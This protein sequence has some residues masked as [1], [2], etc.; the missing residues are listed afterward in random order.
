MVF[1]RCSLEANSQ[2]LPWREY[3]DD[4]RHP[5]Y[6]NGDMVR[7]QNFMEEPEIGLN[8]I[9]QDKNVGKPLILDGKPLRRY[10]YFCSLLTTI[11]WKVP[12][13]LGKIPP[14]PKNDATAEQKGR[15]ALFIMMLFRPWLGQVPDFIVDVLDGYA[16]AFPEDVAWLLLHKELA[17][18]GGRRDCKTIYKSNELCRSRATFRQ[19]GLVGLRDFS[20]TQEHRT[21]YACAKERHSICQAR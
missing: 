6:L 20:E 5:C 17:E 10:P 16:D 18:R 15:Y 12:M 14:T 4:H 13:L 7:S 8:G 9:A 1:L 2:S 11:A 3:T 19:Q 21:R